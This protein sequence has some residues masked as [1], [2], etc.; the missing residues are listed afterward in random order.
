VAQVGHKDGFDQS[1]LMGHSFFRPGADDIGIL[2]PH[3]GHTRHSQYK[4]I[5]GGTNGDVG[6]HWRDTGDNEGSKAEIKKGGVELLAV[7]MGPDTADN[8]YADFAQWIDFTLQYNASTFDTVVIQSIWAGYINNPTYAGNRALQ[9][10]IN[11]SAN[12]MVQQLRDAYPDL[13][14]LH[15]P[16]GEA[17]IRLWALYDQSLLGSEI[18][19]VHQQD[20][21]DNYLQWDNTGHAGDILEDTL[22]LIWHQTLYP[23]TDIRMVSNLPTLQQ[24]W[25]YDIRQ[26]AY[27]IWSSES[28][29]E[30]YNDTPADPSPP[31][32][33]SSPVVE[34]SA[35]VDVAYSGATLSDNA[36]DAN[37]DPLTF[38][39]V[40][41]PAW[42]SVAS[43][44]TLSGTPTHGNTG[45]NGFRVSVSDGIFSTEEDLEISVNSTSSQSYSID[46]ASFESPLNVSGNWGMCP[47]SWNDSGTSLYELNK[48]RHL[49][50]AAD[51][52]WFALVDAMDPLYQ[53]LGVNV[54]AGDTLE[55]SFYG[56][57]AKDSVNTAG[58][59]VLESTFIVDG[60]RYSITADTAQQAPN[61]WQLYTHTVTV[62]NS[63]NL[64]LEFRT[65]S[66]R[67]WLDAI[68]D[69]SVIGA[70]SNTPPVFTLD[71]IS[72]SQAT[73]DVAY[74]DTIAGSATDADIDP[75][76]YSKV[77]GD[78]WLSVAAN[79]DISGTPNAGYIGE[80]LFTIQVSDGNGG[81]D[82]A[83]LE[84]VV[85]E[86]PVS[87]NDLI[88]DDFESFNS[89]GWVT[90]WTQVT[91]H[92]YSS[93]TSLYAGA[94]QNDLIS[95]ALDISGKTAVTLSFRY[96]ISGIDA[97]D[98]VRT[99]ISVGNQFYDVEEIG[100][101]PEGTWLHANVSLTSAQHPNVFRNDFRFKIEASSIDAGEGLWIDDVVITV[102]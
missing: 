77:S 29:A 24:N 67:P 60:T 80:N 83:T 32:F 49:S 12:N 90:D 78:N 1:I 4:Q 31:Y 25:T 68:S 19:G 2:A 33:L 87:T 84:V 34:V 72:V 39:K 99:Q 3:T 46:D 73:A 9:D 56:G 35:S 37:D 57:H 47:T 64:T 8:E 11:A 75:L 51:G 43:D 22:G 26:L 44:G 27:D 70:G 66:G 10:S 82:T 95:P 59:G 89:T 86:V 92:S 97:D 71:P 18:W 50:S 81:I 16:A 88:N 94:G 55:V 36:N 48:S 40:F 42:L 65:L 41:G 28:Y 101:D 63:G 14:I 79:G 7:T 45:F 6:S 98:D 53:D 58:G 93:V 30:R 15:L 20:G 13:T 5:A 91:D 74:S 38:A 54:N 23:E 102:E 85:A 52:S 61:S 69:V 21:R 76:T 100:D 62:T 96:R 17:F